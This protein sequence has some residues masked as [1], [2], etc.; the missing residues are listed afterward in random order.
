MQNL[1]IH[2]VLQYQHDAIILD[3]I[4]VFV[5]T[6]RANNALNQLNN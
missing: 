3:T 1:H 6:I 5:V 4:V 2:A